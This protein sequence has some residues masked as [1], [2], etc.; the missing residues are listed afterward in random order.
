LLIASI[1]AADDQPPGLNALR[2]GRG[3]FLTLRI[4]RW[5]FSVHFH[6]WNL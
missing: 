1:Y 2:F 6:F 4:E 3:R 5:E